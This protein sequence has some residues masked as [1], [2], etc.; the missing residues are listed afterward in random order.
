MLGV[1]T[2][3]EIVVLLLVVVLT[4]ALLAYISAARR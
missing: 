2:L 1:P 4:T 3:V